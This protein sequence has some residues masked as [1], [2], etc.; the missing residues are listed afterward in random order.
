MRSVVVEPRPTTA[1]DLILAGIN[2]TTHRQR[3]SPGELAIDIPTQW[4]LVTSPAMRA[5]VMV[6]GE[7]MGGEDFGFGI[8]DLGVSGCLPAGFGGVFER[9]LL[10]PVL[11]GDDD[12]GG[13]GSDQDQ[14]RQDDQDPGETIESLGHRGW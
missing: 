5:A 12:E 11:D 9:D 13:P 4:T 10:R 6:A 14:E 8:L 3:L 7:V 2:E 1:A